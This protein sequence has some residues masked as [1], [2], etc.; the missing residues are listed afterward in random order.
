MKTISCFASLESLPHS[1]PL[2]K[3]QYPEDLA[4]TIAQ[5]SALLKVNK[6]SVE[7][8]INQRDSLHWDN[9][10]EFKNSVS[11]DFMQSLVDNRYDLQTTLN[12]SDSLYKKLSALAFALFQVE[13]NGGNYFSGNVLLERVV[14]SGGV[15]SYG[16]S[17]GWTQ[18]NMSSQ[19]DDTKKLLKQFDVNKSALWD[20]KKSAIAT[21]IILSE[22]YKYDFPRFRDM[23][24]ENKEQK[25]KKMSDLE[26]MSYIYYKPGEL[27][28]GT[29]SPLSNTRIKKSKKY[30]KIGA[31]IVHLAPLDRLKNVTTSTIHTVK[32]GDTFSGILNRCNISNVVVSKKIIPYITENNASLLNIQVDQQIIIEKTS[33]NILR[34][35]TKNKVLEIN[36]GDRKSIENT[37]NK[38]M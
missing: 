35:S 32:R 20:P 12:L 36:T 37:S 27:K 38:M 28:K 17:I 22:Q 4:N 18:I 10:L 15:L 5:T 26:I 31:Q 8:Y 2:D 23:I 24:H 34:I 29:A 16:K 33:R 25:K 21:M 6:K 1:N 30:F 3:S 13:G 7:N 11:Q 9:N 14:S 19:S